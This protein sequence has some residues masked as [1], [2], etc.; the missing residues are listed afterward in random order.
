MSTLESTWWCSMTRF[1]RKV[2]EFDAMQFLGGTENAAEILAWITTNGGS[3]IYEPAVPPSKD[4]LGRG[5][6]GIP[7]VIRLQTDAGVCWVV[8]DEWIVHQDNKWYYLPNK[9]IEESFEK[10]S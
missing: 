9:E 2:I 3:A 4:E 5:H 6:N 8:P 7:E 1:R 10:V